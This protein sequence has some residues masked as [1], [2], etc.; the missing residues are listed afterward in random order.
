MY[1]IK[2]PQPYASLVVS[3]VMNTLPIP[4]F[5]DLAKGQ[6]VFI[7]A[8][9]FL[10]GFIEQID[11]NKPK[12]RKLSNEIFLG[13]IPDNIDEY[14]THQFVGYVKVSDE[15]PINELDCSEF[16]AKIYITKPHR[17]TKMIV[18]YN[19][20]LSYL[21]AHNAVLVRPRKMRLRK[22]DMTLIVQVGKSTWNDLHNPEQIPSIFMFWEDYMKKYVPGV[23][24][25]VQDYLDEI[26]VQNIQFQ[27]GNDYLNF[28][29]GDGCSGDIIK[30]NGFE[31][32]IEILS[33]RLEYEI[34][35]PNCL[36][37]ISKVRDCDITKRRHK[38]FKDDDEDGKEKSSYVNIISTPMGGQNRWKR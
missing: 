13:N 35:G 33:F 8:L 27:Y 19:V 4:F 24:S 21:E 20:P 14:P 5:D 31:D 15:L 18:N 23:F 28:F 30:P 16:G 26:E 34:G 22:S 37:D 1:K 11:Y 10:E 7:Y 29:S 3:G 17:F 12:F 2:L 38:K 25:F 9:D 32:P 36:I 6:K